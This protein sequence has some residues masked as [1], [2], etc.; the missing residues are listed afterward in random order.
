MTCPIVRR[1]RSM[2]QEL[3]RFRKKKKA[4]NFV[5]MQ[6]ITTDNISGKT[7]FCWTVHHLLGK[8]CRAV[9]YRLS[10]FTKIICP[11]PISKQYTDHER[12]SGIIL[13]RQVA[14]LSLVFFVFCFFLF[15][16]LRFASGTVLSSPVIKLTL[17]SPSCL[18]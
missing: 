5:S 17:P 2:H 7:F 6:A 9:A 3:L 15:F 4:N 14:L 16:F 1:L 12:G 18:V 11:H 8:Y 10:L 13:G